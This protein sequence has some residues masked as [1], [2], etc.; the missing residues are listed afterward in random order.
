MNLRLLGTFVCLLSSCLLGVPAS[1]QELG[2]VVAEFDSPGCCPMGITFARRQLWIADRRANKLYA[3]D[4]GSGKVISELPTP[5]I[6]P[7]G[8]TFDGRHLWVAD[9]D[10]PELF[11]LD[12]RTALVDRVFKTSVRAPR[13]MD[14]RIAPL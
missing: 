10:K 11:R 7:T 4:P 14:Q 6:R 1:A 3:L 12:P 5:G 2:E 9:R 8:I 13:G